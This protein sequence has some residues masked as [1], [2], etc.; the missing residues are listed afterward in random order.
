[1]L[2][3]HERISTRDIGSVIRES[4]ALVVQCKKIDTRNF[5]DRMSLTD[6]EGLQL[7]CD[8]ERKITSGEVREFEEIARVVN[9]VA[10]LLD[11]VNLDTDLAKAASAVSRAILLSFT[12]PSLSLSQ[13]T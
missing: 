7:L 5:G 10:P 9:R 8:L 13:K 4:T 6:R 11:P 1:M 2:A 12:L 3:T